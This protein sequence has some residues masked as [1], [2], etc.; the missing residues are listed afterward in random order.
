MKTWD[1]IT[2]LDACVDLIVSGNTIPRF[3]QI[4][5]NVNNYT[6]EMGGSSSIFLSQ[7]AKLGLSVAGVGCRGDDAFGDFFETEL[8]RTGVDISLLMKHPTEK[9]GLG[10]CLLNEDD[11]AILT[12]SGTINILEERDFPDELLAKAR[13]LHIASYFL[14]RKLRPHF[15]AVVRRAKSLGLT[16]SLDT[17]WDPDGEWLGVSDLLPMI[18]VFLP[19]E[20]EAEAMGGADSLSKKA[21]L[22]IVKEGERGASAYI[23]G[24]VVAQADAYVMPYADA[25]G[26]GDSFDAGFVSAWLKEL[27]IETCLR[28]GCACGSLSIRA[29][30]GIKGQGHT[31]EVNALLHANEHSFIGI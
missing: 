17:N 5:Q 8:G 27:P 29:H 18:D 21:K 20:R 28:Y 23:D 25:I 11:R 31:A 19:N 9:T 15:C 4:E 16:V 30:G 3:H 1:I 14:L 13:H 26:A 24:H 7:C 2:G 6:I 12:Y 22:L 10:L